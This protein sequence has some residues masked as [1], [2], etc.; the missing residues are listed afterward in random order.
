MQQRH[1]MYRLCRLEGRG[2]KLSAEDA[3]PESASDPKAIFVV[4]EVVLQVVLLQLSPVGWQSFV[5]QE[6]MGN[7]VADVPKDATAVNSRS[8]MPVPVE[9]GVC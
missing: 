6:I 9:N 8:N 4:H 3:I 5:V 7:V 2:G 1:I